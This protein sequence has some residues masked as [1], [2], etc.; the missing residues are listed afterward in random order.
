MCCSNKAYIDSDKLSASSALFA[1]CRNFLFSSACFSLQLVFRLVFVCLFLFL[2]LCRCRT[3]VLVN[4]TSYK[5]YLMRQIGFLPKYAWTQPSIEWI[6]QRPR[7]TKCAVWLLEDYCPEV[8][9]LRVKRRCVPGSFLSCDYTEMVCQL[10][11]FGCSSDRLTQ[12]G[13]PKCVPEYE[14]VRLT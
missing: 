1:V 11:S 2:L 12:N 8:Q 10:I 9:Q 6:F 14:W 4:P 7:Q 13:S 3:K 5:N